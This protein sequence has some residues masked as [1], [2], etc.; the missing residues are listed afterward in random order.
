ME[1]TQL[2]LELVSS[3]L[4]IVVLVFIF[5]KY[6]QY[7]KKLSVIKGLNQLKENNSLTP[8]DKDF[9]KKNLK[10]YKAAFIQDESR[11]KMA[12]PI[13][14]LV[15]GILVAF[16]SF[17]E[18]MIHLNVIIVVYIYM[19]ISKIHNKNFVGFLEELN[20]E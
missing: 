14:I 10:D 16:L 11:I 7:K 3:F 6:Y 17:Q 8:E 1:S 5:L 12:Y 18:A 15:G 13:F 20:E 4:S 19:Q 2:P 9:I